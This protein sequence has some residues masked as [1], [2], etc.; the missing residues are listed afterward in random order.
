MRPPS[1]VASVALLAIASS[2]AYA[3]AISSSVPDA[4]V[5]LAPR[6]SGISPLECTLMLQPVQCCQEFE[7]FSAVSG[8]LTPILDDLGIPLP[9][10]GTLIAF[11]CHETI[12]G[13]GC[14]ESTLCCTLVVPSQDIGINCQQV[15][16]LL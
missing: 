8:I 2:A 1:L 5:E 11:D 9:G 13:L 6:Q 7:P 15:D 12:L 4:T 10:L 16:P 3:S 14:T